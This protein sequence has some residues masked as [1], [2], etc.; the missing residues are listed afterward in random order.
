MNSHTLFEGTLPLIK[1][2]AV[3]T[4]DTDSITANSGSSAVFTDMAK[5]K[6]V[7]YLIS[8]NAVNGDTITNITIEQ[9]TSAAGANRKVVAG[10]CFAPT[11]LNVAGETACVE[12]NAESLDM[13][14]GFRFV[15]VRV[16]SGGGT[17]STVNIVEILSQ[18]RYSYAS[19][20][21]YTVRLPQ[22]LA[23]AS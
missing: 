17:S 20:S 9:A 3:N 22:D 19:R 12:L 5:W 11:T 7:A 13:A 4:H 8:L 2:V 10:Y 14:N 16:S 21:G 23:A 15:N 6:H 18:P 1:G